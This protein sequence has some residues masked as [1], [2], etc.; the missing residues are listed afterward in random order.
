MR[1]DVM[2]K[3][4]LSLLAKE[5]AVDKKLIEILVD[6]GYDTREKLYAFLYPTLDNLTDAHKYIG[7]DDVL[8]R[9]NYA[10][11]NGEKILIYGDYDCDGICGTSILYN[12]FK[13]RGADANC[14]LPNRHTDGYGLS[15]ET[16]EKLAE[17]YLSDLLITVDCGIT[18][19][20][21]VEYAR[22]VLGFDVI[23]TDH[24]E[25]G[26]IL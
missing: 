4:Q 1:M 13:S 5:F 23:I 18:S 10:I 24:H 2:D 6:R 3:E 12:F 25:V 16:L 15:I 21:E 19:V 11:E 8:E 22:E 17:E 20:E 7:Y 9:I 26:E 14:F